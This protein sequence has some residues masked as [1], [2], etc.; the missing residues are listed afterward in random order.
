MSIMSTL[1]AIAVFIQV[2]VAT[3]ALL[4]I[5]VDAVTRGWVRRLVRGWLGIRQL[6]EDHHDT[7]TFLLDLGD[8]YNDLAE[9][10]GPES[11]DQ[12]DVDYYKRR[13][14]ETDGVQR[15]DFVT[16]DDD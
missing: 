6:R 3:A 1:S 7:Q 16:D 5:V 8:A 12:V 14:D 4:G 10:V 9:Y 13:L 11:V 15:G 2:A